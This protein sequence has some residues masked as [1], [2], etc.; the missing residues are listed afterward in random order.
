MKGGEK[1][2]GGGKVGERRTH[3]K[4]RDGTRGTRRE[5]KKQRKKER[6]WRE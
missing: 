3:H 6:E 4:S 1:R 2:D 5:R